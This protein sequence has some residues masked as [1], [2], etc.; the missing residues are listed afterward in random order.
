M[1]SV[2]VEISFE[3]ELE[4]KDF[5]LMKSTGTLESFKSNLKEELEEEFEEYRNLTVFVSE[6]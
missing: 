6:I 3:Y 5:S 1:A 4:G 2:R